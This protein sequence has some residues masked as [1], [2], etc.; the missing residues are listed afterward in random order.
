ML[1]PMM[2]ERRRCVGISART[3]RYSVDMQTIKHKQCF[4]AKKQFNVSFGSVKTILWHN[5]WWQRAPVARRLV[6]GLQTN[7]AAMAVEDTP[8]RGYTT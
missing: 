1:E 2:C 8:L 6:Q 5:Y 3:R 7:R 4:E